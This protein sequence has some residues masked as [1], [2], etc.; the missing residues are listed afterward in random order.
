MLSYRNRLDR[1]YRG[2]G[3][4]EEK[5]AGK[6]RLFD[7]MIE[8][9]TALKKSWGGFAGYDRLFARRP[10]NALLASIAA[11]TE[12][13]PAFRGMIAQAGGDMQRFYAE[14]KKIADLPA[15]ERRA[16]L[17]GPPIAGDGAG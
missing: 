12:L 15:P 11:Y 5:R 7:E 16:R 6:A 13:V 10:N 2:P 9:Y 4:A 14:V 1:F 8:E 17:G 3:T